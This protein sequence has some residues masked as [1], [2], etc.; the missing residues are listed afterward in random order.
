MGPATAITWPLWRWADESCDGSVVRVDVTADQPTLSWAAPSLMGAPLPPTG[1]RG[2]LTRANPADACAPLRKKLPPH[3]LV[4]A[5]RGGC[6]FSAKAE[7]VRA[8]GG[9]ALIISQAP[10]PSDG[11]ICFWVGTGP[12]A[13][14]TEVAGLPPTFSTDAAT[15][16]RLVAAAGKEATLVLPDNLGGPDPG[17]AILAALAVAGV[18]LGAVAAAQDELGVD[19]EEALSA[20]GEG[21]ALLAIEGGATTAPAPDHAAAQ[22]LDSRAA[23]ALVAGMACVLVTAWAL[24]TLAGW[25]LSGG[26]LIGSCDAAARA[27]AAA[28]GTGGML[29]RST[30][31]AAATTLTAAIALAWLARGPRGVWPLHDLLALALA[32]VVPRSLRL[33]SLAS[34]VTLLACA[35]LND[36]WWVFIQ[37]AL[38]G[39]ASV[40]VAVAS[41]TPALVFLAP[42]FRGGP[43]AGVGLV[44]LGDCV[45]PALAVAAVAR[46]E[47]RHGSARGG[48]CSPSPLTRWRCTVAA[49]CGYGVG[50]C[51][52][53]AA[54][55]AGVGGSAGQPAL[56]YLSPAVTC[57]AVGAAAVGGELRAQWGGVGVEE[58][59]EGMVV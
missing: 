51:A 48:G 35:A 12:E 30:A 40:M 54:L 15:G 46:W 42:L 53:Y 3:A 28:L 45:I 10:D 19:G 14:A 41:T 27:A 59:E 5:T 9:A 21:G 36:A 44:G 38:T 7:A 13:N 26:F 4:I 49:V 57:A 31:R 34:A 11:A 33:T 18:I 1:L 20:E 6:N 25:L 8:A 39:G 58:E 17:A 16:A 52:T 47:A 23:L 55:L 56:I 32:A 50:L 22:S 2:T 29:S 43:H 37:P 24:P